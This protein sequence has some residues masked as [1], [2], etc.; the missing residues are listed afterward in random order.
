MYFPLDRK[1]EVTD[2]G[3]EPLVQEVGTVSNGHLNNPAETLILPHTD[4]THSPDSE[5]EEG[6]DDDEEEEQALSVES[7]DNLKPQPAEGEFTSD[8]TEPVNVDVLDEETLSGLEVQAAELV[9]DHPTLFQSV[10]KSK[11]SILVIN[12]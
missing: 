6:K 1:E 8:I 12:S 4:K 5:E 10:E 3:A 9:D 11:D 7:I 2:L